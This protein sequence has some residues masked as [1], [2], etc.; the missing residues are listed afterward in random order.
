MVLQGKPGSR[1]KTFWDVFIISENSIFQILAYNTYDSA[2]WCE[3][4][5]LKQGW[6][7]STIFP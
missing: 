3:H 1:K 6:F 4:V 2:D 5:A 7:I